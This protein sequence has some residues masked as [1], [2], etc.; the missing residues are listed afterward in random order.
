M[1]IS[2]C[3]SDVCSSDLMHDMMECADC[4]MVLWRVQMTREAGQFRAVR[5]GRD[6]EEDLQDVEE[7]MRQ[8]PDALGKKIMEQARSQRMDE[9]KSNIRGGK[10]GARHVAFAVQRDADEDDSDYD[11]EVNDDDDASQ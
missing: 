8:M 6:E 1:R 4:V 9:M 2:D 11:D 5:R 3:S 7:D 10:G